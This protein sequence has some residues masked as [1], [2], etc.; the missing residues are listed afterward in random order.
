LY[1]QR[2]AEHPEFGAKLDESCCWIRAAYPS[3]GAGWGHQFILRIGQEV[4]IRFIDGD[5]YR[6]PLSLALSINGELK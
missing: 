3:V 6:P 2:A 5:T 1:W 4:T